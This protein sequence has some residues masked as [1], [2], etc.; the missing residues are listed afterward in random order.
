MKSKPYTERTPVTQYA[1]EVSLSQDGLVKYKLLRRSPGQFDW[2]PAPLLT[3]IV[4]P[5]PSH[6]EITSGILH[7]EGYAYHEAMCI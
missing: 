3:V 1:T 4:L 6:K 7:D 2:M 5:K